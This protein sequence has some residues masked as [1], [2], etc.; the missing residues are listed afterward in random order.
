MRIDLDGI[1]AQAGSMRRQHDQ[2]GQLYDS[3]KGLSAFIDP[4]QAHYA[5]VHRELQRELEQLEQEGRLLLQ[6]AEVLV[7]TE[8]CVKQTEE[9]VRE[10]YGGNGICYARPWICRILLDQIAPC[11]WAIRLWGT[12][13]EGETHG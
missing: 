11:P 3:L 4:S 6:M 13:E 9:Q 5:D 7:E 2:I 1:T 12:I 8:R 10:V